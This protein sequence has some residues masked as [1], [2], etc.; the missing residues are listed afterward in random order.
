MDEPFLPWWV[1]VLLGMWSISLTVWQHASIHREVRMWAGCLSLVYLTLIFLALGVGLRTPVTTPVQLTRIPL[2]SFGFGLCGL[3]SLTAS[4]WLLGRIS[5]T[6]RQLCYIVATLANASVCAILQVPV[7]SI[8]LLIV[9]AIA[10]VPLFARRESA[11]S[12]RTAWAD[13]LKFDEKPVDHEASGKSWLTGGLTMLLV[14]V[15]L[16]TTAYAL[17]YEVMRENGSA[18]KSV[19]PSRSQVDEVLFSGKA[20]AG[21][22]SLLNYATSTRADIVVLMAAIVFLTLASTGSQRATPT[23]SSDQNDDP[24]AMEPVRRS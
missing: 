22:P 18:R 1:V 12:W 23:M 19:H 3:V 14:C 20:A 13:L 15:L 21:E 7:I 10:A 11:L 9:A 16:G 2:R 4:V 8:G 24:A 17:R 6:A 5:R